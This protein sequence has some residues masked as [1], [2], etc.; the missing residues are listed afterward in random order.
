MV[1]DDGS[2]KP[3]RE[4][5]SGN[6]VLTCYEGTGQTGVKTVAHKFACFTPDTLVRCLQSDETIKEIETT[7]ERPCY[8]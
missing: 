7:L 1:M 5:K 4:I 8:V 2:T 3:I 6:K